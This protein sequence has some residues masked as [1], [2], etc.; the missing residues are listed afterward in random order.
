MNDFRSEQSQARGSR[1]KRMIFADGFRKFTSIPVN[2]GIDQLLPAEGSRDVHHKRIDFYR[3]VR[4][5]KHTLASGTEA[6]RDRNRH[7]NIAIVQ[8]FDFTHV[9]SP[10]SAILCQRFSVLFPV[11][12]PTRPLSPPEDE[13]SGCIRR[14]TARSRIPL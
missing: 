8:N 7:Q 13:R 11:C 12:P 14:A 4:R 9:Q 1:H 3:I 5:K 2:A 10:P 6:K